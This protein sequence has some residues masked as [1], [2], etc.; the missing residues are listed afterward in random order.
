MRSFL[1]RELN[2]SAYL[3]VFLE[4]VFENRRSHY[5][6]SASK[7]H[8]E[9]HHRGDKKRGVALSDTKRVEECGC[10]IRCARIITFL[11]LADVGSK[12]P[13]FPSEPT[14]SLAQPMCTGSMLSRLMV[15]SSNA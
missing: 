15:N 12:Y 2:F 1:P 8:D 10:T 3:V 14:V 13:S 5:A 7:E 6:S 9:S 11:E 4:F